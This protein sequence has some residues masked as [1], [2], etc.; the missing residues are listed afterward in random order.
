[1]AMP[2]FM[3]NMPG[4]WRRPFDR[5]QRHAVEL[6]DR[7]HCIEVAEQQN[8]GGA[9]PKFRDQVIA[10]IRTRQ[11]GNA[12]ADRLEP[13]RERRPAPVHRG[14]IGRRRFDRHECLGRLEHPVAVGAAEI[15][16]AY[17]RGHG[18]DR[19]EDT[20]GTEVTK[21]E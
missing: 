17:N 19:A 6:A 20:E 10:A 16:E 21:E 14:F 3:S 12:P 2:A 4:P 11:A 8:L 9:A 18:S 1:M 7:P 13:R 5:R 15:A